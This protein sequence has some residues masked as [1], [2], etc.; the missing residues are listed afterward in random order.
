MFTAAWKIKEN[1][2]QHDCARSEKLPE[3]LRSTQRSAHAYTRSTLEKSS[4]RDRRPSF[5]AILSLSAALE[6]SPATFF[7]FE[8]AEVN[9]GVLRKRIEALPD[10]A[11]PQRLPQ[12]IER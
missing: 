1:P 8:H 12:G 7:E 10:R 6:T 9:E 11:G 3:S 2:L 5:E 4:R